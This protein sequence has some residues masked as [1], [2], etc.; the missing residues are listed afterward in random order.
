MYLSE[1]NAKYIFREE[2]L[3]LEEGVTS[4]TLKEFF[5]SPPF[6]REGHTGEPKGASESTV[7]SGKGQT[8]EPKRIQRSNTKL[9][10]SYTHL[11]LPTN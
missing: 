11:T 5:K 1:A 6:F 3:T 8:E 9:T 10:V 4:G 2:A 7:L